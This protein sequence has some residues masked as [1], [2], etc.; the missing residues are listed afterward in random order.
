M[1]PR[2]RRGVCVVLLSVLLVFLLAPGAAYAARFS[3]KY[4]L[5]ICDI[6]P[7][8]REVIAG[9]HAACQAYIAG[10]LDYHAFLQ[11]LKIAPKTDI[12]VPH[13]VSMNQVHATVLN[14]LKNNPQHDGFTAAPAVTTALFQAYPCRRGR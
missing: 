6:G 7:D 12:C 5:E 4:L 14:Y 3:G 8:G 11:G 1:T 2:A 13:S 9:G 10:V